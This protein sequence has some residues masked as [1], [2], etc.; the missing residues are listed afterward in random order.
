MEERLTFKI[1]NDQGVEVDCEALFTFESDETKKHYMVYTDNTTDEDGN[2]KLY[3]GTFNPEDEAGVLK[4][5]ETEEEWK[6]IEEV[7]AEIQ[8][9]YEE[10]SEQ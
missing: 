4:P 1:K 9:E 8:E 3:A 7:I 6:I 10:E 2:T 5:I